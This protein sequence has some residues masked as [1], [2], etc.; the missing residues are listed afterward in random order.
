MTVA[1]RFLQDQAASAEIDIL[2]VKGS[3]VSVLVLVDPADCCLRSV[4]QC[5]VS[6]GSA[7]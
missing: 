7:V 6:A 5:P 1:V 3:V 4:R 2:D